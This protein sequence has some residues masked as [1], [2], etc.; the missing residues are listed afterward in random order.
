MRRRTGNVK[1]RWHEPAASFLPEE[2]V[3]NAPASSEAAG[4]D[5]R[6]WTTVGARFKAVLI[7]SHAFIGLMLVCLCMASTHGP[8]ALLHQLL[9]PAAPHIYDWR[10][11]DTVDAMQQPKKEKHKV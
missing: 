8:Q 2:C 11:E 4:N 5:V 10:T 6:M 9:L 3:K 1:H 7:F